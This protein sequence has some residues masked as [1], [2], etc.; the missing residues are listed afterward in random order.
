M[1]VA[2]FPNRRTDVG[3]RRAPGTFG[4]RVAANR[5]AKQNSRTGKPTITG[6]Q[7]YTGRTMGPVG[8]Y[9]RVPGFGR[10]FRG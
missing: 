8:Q 1:P 3:G 5:K 6:W 2:Q 10:S 9:S 4:E 7:D